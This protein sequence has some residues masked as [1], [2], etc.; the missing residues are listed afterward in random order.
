[1]ECQLDRDLKAEKARSK[2]L[3]GPRAIVDARGSLLSSLEGPVGPLASM[4]TA[5]DA[6]RVDG[7]ENMA[8][9]PVQPAAGDSKVSNRSCGL[10]IQRAMTANRKK[11]VRNGV[12]K[13]TGRLMVA[14]NVRRRPS[15]CPLNH[16]HLRSSQDGPKW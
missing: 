11:K 16:C 6:A 3:S 13:V 14:A 8:A 9:E 7:K 2:V 1:M 5:A 4:D 15:Q 12:G 10:G